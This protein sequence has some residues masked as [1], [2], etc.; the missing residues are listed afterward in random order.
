M[1]ELRGAAA[2]LE[3]LGPVHHA[4]ARIV[5]A[6]RLPAPP[7]AAVVALMGVVDDELARLLADPPARGLGALGRQVGALRR[8][9]GRRPDVERAPVPTQ[10]AL[11]PLGDAL[12]ALWDPLSRLR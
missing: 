3:E 7:E 8:L 10:E 12:D 2:R 11:R 5:R 9:N 4:Q 6:A 1:A